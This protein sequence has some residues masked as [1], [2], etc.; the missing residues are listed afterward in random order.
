MG[1]RLVHEL[2]GEV[3]V[4]GARKPLSY[5]Q[6]VESVGARPHEV[7]HDL[8]W[9]RVETGDLPVVREMRDLAH[10]VDLVR[11]P[12]DRVLD[13]RAAALVDVRDGHE[14]VLLERA[15]RHAQLRRVEPRRGDPAPLA[16]AAVPHL[17]EGLEEMTAGDGLGARHPDDAAAALGRVLAAGLGSAVADENGP[18]CDDRAHELVAPHAWPPPP[19]SATPFAPFDP[20]ASLR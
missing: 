20:F 19:R 2:V 11:G 1:G 9:L 18:R 8:G 3:L 4:G 14:V 12:Q 13:L 5:A 16:V 10:V 17:D 7:L 6:R 15:A